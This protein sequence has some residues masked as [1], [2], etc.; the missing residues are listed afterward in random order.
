ML[1]Q[2]PGNEKATFMFA[3]LMLMKDKTDDAIRTYT[4]LLEKTPDNF[5][6]IS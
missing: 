4:Q 6:S 5:L 2:D 3:N 1:K